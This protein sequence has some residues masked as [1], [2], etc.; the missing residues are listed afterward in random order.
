MNRLRL[1]LPLTFVSLLGLGWAVAPVPHQDVKI[2][3]QHVSGPVHMLEGMG[4]NIGASVGA[5]GVLMIDDQFADIAPLIQRTLTDLATE[6]GL[7]SGAPRY[8]IN[9]HHHGD[10]TGGNAIFGTSAT[11]IAHEN[12]RGRLLA[13]KDGE[14]MVAAGLP[15]VTFPDGLSIHFNGEEIRLLHL[16]NGHTDGDTMVHFTGSNVVHTGDQCFNGRFPYIDLDSGGSVKGYVKNLERM[17][18]LTDADTQFIPGHGPLGTRADIEGLQ[19][20][21]ESCLL[22]V[23]GALSDGK[24]EEQMRLD[25]LLGEFEHLDWRFI[26]RDAMIAIIVRELTAQAASDE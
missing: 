12:V 2:L 8:L 9:T 13:P 16:P 17:L 10:H 4:G 11:I 7:E 23:S 20:S 1:A 15:V 14:P 19:S 22:L 24:S 25:N 6:A 21:L 26:D 5:D 18:E 3:P